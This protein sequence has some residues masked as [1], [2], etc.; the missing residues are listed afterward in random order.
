MT[1][2]MAIHWNVVWFIDFF[3]FLPCSLYSVSFLIL[4]LYTIIVKNGFSIEYNDWVSH[5]IYL[6]I[7]KKS[8]ND[9]CLITQHYSIPIPYF[10]QR[11]DLRKNRNTLTMRFKFFLPN[12]ILQTFVQ[13]VGIFFCYLVSSSLFFVVTFP[14]KNYIKL[15]IFNEAC[16]LIS[17][18]LSFCLSYLSF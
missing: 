8:F 5:F 14:V 18:Y 4:D 6:T 17:Y 13:L 7:P 1:F 9:S 10:C 2:T 12:L 11:N 3:H 16:I 15:S